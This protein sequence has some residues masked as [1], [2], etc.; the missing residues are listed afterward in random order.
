MNTE[1]FDTFIQAPPKKVW[2]TMLQS[3]TYVRWATALFEGS[4]FEGA[5]DEGQK[6]RL[7]GPQGLGLIDKGIEDTTSE[8]VRAWA[9]CF[10]NYTFAEKAGGTRLRVD[11]DVFGNCEDWMG[12]T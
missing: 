9:P 6:I 8:A 3:P 7:V 2:A 10:D 1:R 12:Q 5:W 4:R 11:C